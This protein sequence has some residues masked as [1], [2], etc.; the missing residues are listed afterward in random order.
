[1][2][3]AYITEI[4]FENKYIVRNT[5]LVPFHVPRAWP[6]W[7]CDALIAC[8]DLH[9]S[10]SWQYVL[11]HIIRDRSRSRPFA[12][13]SVHALPLPAYRCLRTDMSYLLSKI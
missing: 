10:I 3:G 12:I 11:S 13:A 9:C 1:M 5:Y 2:T 4:I 7:R 6:V 8:N